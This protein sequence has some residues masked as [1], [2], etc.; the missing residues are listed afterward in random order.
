MRITVNGQCQEVADGTNVADLLESL[1]L[2][3]LRVAV[4][5]NKQLVPRAQHAGTALG[6]DDSLEI[7]TLVGGG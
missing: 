7:V 1:S 5:R 4:E 2:Q 3:P 6:E